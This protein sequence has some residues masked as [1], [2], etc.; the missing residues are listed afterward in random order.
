MGEERGIPSDD[1]TSH[2]KDRPIECCMTVMHTYHTPGRADRQM[3]L[4]CTSLFLLGLFMDR[5]TYWMDVDLLPRT[6]PPAQLS[7]RRLLGCL[8]LCVL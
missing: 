1:I 3:C 5:C 6:L 2:T 8:A 4:H 7:V